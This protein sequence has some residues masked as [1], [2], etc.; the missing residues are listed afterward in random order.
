MPSRTLSRSPVFG[1]DAASFVQPYCLPTHPCFP[2]LDRWASLNA[3]TSG[4]LFR[5]DGD[6]PCDAASCADPW[7]RIEQ[8]AAVMFLNF[9]NGQGL[10]PSL[11]T[12]PNQ[13]AQSVEEAA[14]SAQDRTPAYV[15]EALHAEDAVA[16]VNYARE[17]RLRLRVKNT[18][19]DYLGRSSDPG[20]FTLW[21]NKLKNREY[22]AQFV[23][24]GAPEGTQPEKAIRAGAGNVVQD[25]YQAADE[26]GVVVTAGV[27]RTVGG[28]GGFA[29][30]GGHGPFAPLHGLAAD[31]ILEFTVVTANGTLLRTS[32][33]QHPTLFTALRGGGSAFAVVVET[34]FRVHTPPAGFVGIFGEFSVAKNA[35]K[36]DG[37]EAW[38][39]LMKRWVGLQPKLSDA[40]PFAGYTYVQRPAGTPFAYVLPT[41]NIALARE[42]FTPVF[43]WADKDPSIDIEYKYVEEENWYKLWH[44]PFTDA[45]ESLDAVGIPLLLGSRLVPK[46]VVE[47]K[48]DDLAAFLATSS[49]P[50]VVHLVAGGKVQEEPA[51]PS[52]VNPA[53]RHAL[54]HIDLPI[55]WS[56]TSSSSSSIAALSKYLTAHTL[57]LGSIA[58][59]LGHAEASYSSESNYHEPEQRWSGIWY[60]EENYEALL[61]AKREWDPE[62][63][64]TARRAVGSEVVGW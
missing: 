13:T 40:A 4:R 22:D 32:P 33:Y 39:E 25:L 1:S 35:T 27:S 55:S 60:G 54:L 17:H 23:P 36:E 6:V 53:W 34:V 5:P 50:A 7:W 31:N 49:S 42:L 52:S 58:S 16:A 57:S 2:S 48:G 63:V 45:L 30:G 3:T 8:P 64:F 26:A 11:G 12:H 46:E 41:P 44:G 51:H 29:L 37:D 59:S 24:A 9:E 62:G 61:R 19:H 20:S 28:A 14:S 56:S 47:K 15:L 10:D 18:G 21:T 43:Q 38:K